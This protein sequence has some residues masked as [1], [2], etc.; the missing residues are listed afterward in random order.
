MAWTIIGVPAPSRAGWVRVAY[1]PSSCS[2]VGRVERQILG[3]LGLPPVAVRQELLLVVEQLLM[4]LGGKLEVRP[5]DDRID[6]AGLLAIAAIDALGHIDVVAGRTP[7]A[8]LP[9]LG[10]DR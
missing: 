7:A 10:L 6:R 8:I 9:R 2:P 4:R 1:Q 5:F 3:D